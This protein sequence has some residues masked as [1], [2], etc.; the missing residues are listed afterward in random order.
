VGNEKAQAGYAVRALTV[1]NDEL[2]AGGDFNNAAG[3]DVNGIARWNGSAWQPLSSGV[4]GTRFFVEALIP[5]NGKLIA[6][7]NFTKAGG[8]DVNNIAAWDGNSWQPMDGG[9]NNWVYALTIYNGEL[10]AGGNFGKTGPSGIARWDGISWQPMGSGTSGPY[11][12][13]V[14]LTSY[15]GDLI[16]GGWFT[17]AG[18]IPSVYWARWGVS[19]PIATD[20]NL[21]S[22]WMYQNL[23]GQTKS[24]I[25]ATVSDINDLCGN[26][27][28]T[29]YWS[30]ELP[31][32]VNVKPITIAGGDLNDSF[33]T[34]AAPS[35]NETNSISNSG[36]TFKVRVE[37]VGNDFSNYGMAEKEFAIALLGD[38][39]NDTVVD[40]IDRSIANIFWRTGAAGPYKLKDCDLNCDGMVDVIDRSIANLVWR[41]TVGSNSVGSPCPLR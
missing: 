15:K 12:Y 23:P 8:I 31:G 18:G 6:G 11:P 3:V 27:S 38:I 39:N 29:Y 25:T 14:A 26:S 21:S 28:Y 36:Q 20:M 13:V 40:V 30:I 37:M 7:G 22:L 19:E 9:L 2:I 33:W 41:G 16:A 17:T 10:T 5:F 34:F 35:C 32:D 1:Y 24:A 4:S